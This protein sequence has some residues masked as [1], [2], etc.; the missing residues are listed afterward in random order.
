MNDVQRDELNNFLS[1]EMAH[2][3]SRIICKIKEI[4]ERDRK[5]AVEEAIENTKKE[6]LAKQKDKERFRQDEYIR[7]ILEQ[8]EAFILDHY[9]SG[10]DT[11]N[12]AR[13]INA[14]FRAGD[15][16]QFLCDVIPMELVYE[17]YNAEGMYPSKIARHPQVKLTTNQVRRILNMEPV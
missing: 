6:I 4:E 2:F 10:T 3:T 17:L 8:N 15:V 12:I 14:D 13:V 5:K 11:A 16:E 1:V 9:W 7:N